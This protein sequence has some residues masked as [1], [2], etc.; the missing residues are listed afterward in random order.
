MA[1]VALSVLVFDRTGSAF[2]TAAVYALTFLPEILG[3]TWLPGIA[4][5]YP[6]RTVMIACD[7][8]RAVLVGA[9]AIP[10]MPIAAICALLVVAILAGRPFRAAETALLP[11]IFSDEPYVVATGLRMMT[12][13]LAQLAG[14]SLGGIAIAVVGARGGLAIDAATFVVSA[15]LITVYIHRRP[16]PA[17][18]EDDPDRLASTSTRVAIKLL[19]RDPSMR[20]LVGLGWLAAFFVAPE[21]L[22]AAY[23]ATI[24]PGPTRVGL[25]LA[26]IASGCALGTY[27]L[28]RVLPQYRQHVLLGPLAIAAGIPLLACAL[29]PGLIV[30][31]LLWAMSG[32][33]S[34][35]Q[36]LAAAW[37]IKALPAHRRGQIIGLV[38]SGLVTIQGVGILGFGAVADY[39]GPAGA[40]A[41]AGAAGSALAV[42]LAVAWARIP[43]ELPDRYRPRHRG[44]IG[45]REPSRHH[46]TGRV[47]AA[48]D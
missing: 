20:V 36:V 16:A 9:M 46:K 18:P 27:L 29:K 17:A 35:Y 1:R 39:I 8:L 12:D 42:P 13:Q 38:G 4:D 28:V 21:G 26:A 19:W 37:L 31:L 40:V 2:T 22:A 45:P 32:V 47:P 3:G 41:V 48:S 14:F 5:R 11:D 43:W 15:A 10:H 23:A 44:A 7:L 6:R 24:G 25:L 33:F 34:A 30:S